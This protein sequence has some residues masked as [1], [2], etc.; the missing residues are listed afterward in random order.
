M[1]RL[2]SMTLE[3]FSK[4]NSSLIPQGSQHGVY[5]QQSQH[6]PS[7]PGLPELLPEWHRVD[8]WLSPCLGDSQLSRVSPARLPEVQR[9]FEGAGSSV[10]LS[11]ERARKPLGSHPA[12]LGAL[13]WQQAWLWPMALW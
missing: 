4:H 10:I 1:S 9:L 3:A 7:Q 6:G 2:D 11:L 8:L 12:L 13:R 5:T